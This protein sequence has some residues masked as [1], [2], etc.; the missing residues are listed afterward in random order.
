VVERRTYYEILGVAP[1]AS[2]AEIRAAFRQ[3]ARERHPD[4]FSGSARREAELEFQAISEAYNV[5]VDPQ[6]RVRY[7]QSLSG[8][9]ATARSNP[10]ELAKAMVAR[11]VVAMKNGE[12]QQAGEL[13]AQAVAHDPENAKARHLYG[14]F[15]AQHGGRLEEG[16]R[17]LDQAVK[18]DSMNVKLLMDASRLFAKARMFARATRFARMAAELAPDDPTVES[19]LLQVEEGARRGDVPRG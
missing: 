14:L 2:V 1:D 7:D 16:L 19:W 6:A 13:L 11:A 3:L 4:R 9:T 8:T 17:Q 18:L 15:L 12:T 10:R 5:L